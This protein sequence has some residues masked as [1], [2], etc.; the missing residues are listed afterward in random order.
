MKKP[1]TRHQP[2]NSVRNM[3]ELGDRATD[4]L[5]PEFGAAEPVFWI[6]TNETSIRTGH[7][8]WRG[9]NRR[10]MRDGREVRLPNLAHSAES[11]YAPGTRVLHPRARTRYR[12]V[13]DHDGHEI[14]STISNAAAHLPHV[15]DGRYSSDGYAAMMLAKHRALGWISVDAGCLKRQVADGLVDARRLLVDLSKAKVCPKD[16]ATCK[17]LDAEREARQAANA[18]KMEKLEIAASSKQIAADVRQAKAIAD[19]LRGIQ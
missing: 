7:G 6:T 8:Q 9:N 18:A 12:I 15:I 19:A 16:A 11:D 2:E 13:I 10:R 3:R 1:I 5:G 4:N 14:A 17:H